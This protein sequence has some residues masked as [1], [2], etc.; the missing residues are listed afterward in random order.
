[1]QGFGGSL[2]LPVT[3]VMNGAFSNAVA[4]IDDNLDID[5]GG[6]KPWELL[7]QG[8]SILFVPYS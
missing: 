7:V 5:C 4:T 8:A 6:P 3:G 1:M 2:V